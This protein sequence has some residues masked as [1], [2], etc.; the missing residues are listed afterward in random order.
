MVV[1]V[2]LCFKGQRGQWSPLDRGLVGRGPDR[3]AGLCPQESGAFTCFVLCAV[4]AS[5]P[6]GGGGRSR[7]C[8]KG[9]MAGP[10]T[11]H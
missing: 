5:F 3:H 4:C 9:S 6:S 11:D 10:L 7:P 2:V 8:P 1:F